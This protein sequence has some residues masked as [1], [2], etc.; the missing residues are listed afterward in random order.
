MKITVA[1]LPLLAFGALQFALGE[2]HE[3]V[4]TGLGRLLCGCWGSRDFNVWSLCATCDHAPLRNLA[5][6]Y[7]GP[8]FTFAMMWWGY[9]LLAP[10]N[11][12]TPSPNGRWALRWCLP[13]CPS[14]AYSARCS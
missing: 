4:H 3:L 14:L 2:A 9:Y 7:A 13:T 11:P 8:L 10:S 6:T 12:V 1:W 5:A